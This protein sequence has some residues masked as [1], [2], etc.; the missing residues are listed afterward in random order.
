MG[1]IRYFKPELSIPLA[2]GSGCHKDFMDASSQAA[3]S[4]GARAT[5]HAV[6]WWQACAYLPE[7]HVFFVQ[8]GSWL[9]GDVELRAV[10]VAALVGHPEDPSSLVTDREAFI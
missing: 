6:P 2:R 8:V 10:A 9:E 3:V 1:V 7:S 4:C 5:S